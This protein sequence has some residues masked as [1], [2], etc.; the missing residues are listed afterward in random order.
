MAHKLDIM[1]E[2]KSRNP[3]EGRAAP[4]VAAAVQRNGNSDWQKRVQQQRRQI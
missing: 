1:C 2:C 3:A 4:Q